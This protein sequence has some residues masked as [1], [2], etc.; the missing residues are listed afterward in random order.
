MNTE[1]I[2]TEMLKTL[3]NLVL[4]RKSFSAYDVTKALRDKQIIGVVHKN[5]RPLVHEFMKTLVGI[6]NYTVTDNGTYQVYSPLDLYDEEYE[7]A[8]FGLEDYLDQKLSSPKVD[9]GLKK[10]YVG[11][12]RP[13]MTFDNDLPL[14]KGDKFWDSVVSHSEAV[15]KAKEC[16]SC[17]PDCTKQV[18][19]KVED[20]N[21]L[22]KSAPKLTEQ[23]M[24]QKLL[25]QFSELIADLFYKKK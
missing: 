7:D 6:S 23:E 2:V 14:S 16:K 19:K 15:S 11:T 1:Q 24:D 4:H 5:V 21:L 13:V 18:C 17:D 25:Q 3:N 20:K 8:P 12:E 9:L 10:A 22:N